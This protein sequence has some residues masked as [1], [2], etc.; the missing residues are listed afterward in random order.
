MTDCLEAYVGNKAGY[1]AQDVLELLEIVECSVL[2]MT[3]AIKDDLERA[4]A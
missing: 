4:N 2:T 1:T 3:D